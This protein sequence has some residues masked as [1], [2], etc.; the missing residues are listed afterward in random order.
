MPHYESDS[1]NALI[2]KLK[3]RQGA[4]QTSGQVS[5][6]PQPIPATPAAPQRPKT[7]EEMQLEKQGKVK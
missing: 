4:A 3:E 2:A 5:N 6:A 7:Y 1:L